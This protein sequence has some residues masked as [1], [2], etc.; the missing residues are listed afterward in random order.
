MV[1][2]ISV[3]LEESL[4]YLDIKEDGIYV[5]CTLGGGGHSLEIVKQLT[6]GHLYAF[7]QDD[8]AIQ[9]AKQ[10]LSNY[11]DNYTIINENFEFI[12]EELNAR[13]VTQVDGILYDLGVSSF[14]FDIPERGFSYKFDA[15]LDM[16]MDVSSALT[17][18]TIVNEWSFHDIKNILNQY[19]DEKHAKYIARQI[20]HDRKNAPINTTFELVAVIKR[21]LPEKV[22]RT[23]GHPAKKTFQALRIAVN[24]E[25]HVF[26]RSLQQ[27]CDLV[28]KDGRVVVISFQ[29]LEDK[30]AKK[31]FRDK[32]TSNIPKS[33][34]IINDD[35]IE[36]ESLH[37]KVITPS[38]EELANNN[39]AHSAKL[40][41][42]KKL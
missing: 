10:K 24:N 15:D 22:L 40:R 13:N 41:A 14:H 11:E 19:A 16:R 42:I 39:R 34:P 27:A 25:L 5:D 31:I 26:E 35:T 37:R 20:E 8:F 3:L 21:A 38:D 1:K 30:I 4:D 18:K 28:R 17:A 36:F 33:V 7:D 2:H 9:Q 23:K 32:T 6:T 29:S 12:K